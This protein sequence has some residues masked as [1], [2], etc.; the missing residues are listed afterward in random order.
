MNN[1][2]RPSFLTVPEDGSSKDPTPNGTVSSKTSG[3]SSL[4]YRQQAAILMA[5]IKSDMKGSKRI[6]SGDTE[7]SH[8]RGDDTTE[9][10]VASADITVP[11]LRS[12][13]GDT[14]TLTRLR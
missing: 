13:A 2:G 7:M 6:F 8:L 1:A 10:S 14:N 3:Y 12:R 5:Q 4:A 9:A 11:S